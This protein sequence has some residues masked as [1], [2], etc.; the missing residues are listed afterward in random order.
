MGIK[1][2]GNLSNIGGCIQENVAIGADSLC[3]WL[4][5]VVSIAKKGVC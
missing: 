1:V 3:L 5:W 2:N 4:L